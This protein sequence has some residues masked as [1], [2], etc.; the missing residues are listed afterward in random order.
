MKTP[1]S[2]D[3]QDA[4]GSRCG[5]GSLNPLGARRS[6][7]AGGSPRLS[8]GSTR[9][10]SIRLPTA[11]RA[12]SSFPAVGGQAIERSHDWFGTAVLEEQA[13][14]SD[15]VMPHHGGIR[16]NWAKGVSFN[17][18][19]VPVNSYLVGFRSGCPDRT[20]LG[21]ASN[22]VDSGPVL[23]NHGFRVRIN[24]AARSAKAAEMEFSAGSRVAMGC[25]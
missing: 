21:M 18:L 2:A 11:V 3:W 16:Q 6:L 5:I 20:G 13:A 17:Y 14:V 15:S 1:V 23:S 7:V 4:P 8:T 10:D 25:P 19:S 24:F 12:R 9:S 22:P